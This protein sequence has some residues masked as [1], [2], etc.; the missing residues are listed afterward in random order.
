MLTIALYSVVFG[1]VGGYFGR[2][3]YEGMHAFRERRRHRRAAK[4]QLRT[5]AKQSPYYQFR[6]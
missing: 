2:L 6:E 1:I 4:E 3:A 5:M